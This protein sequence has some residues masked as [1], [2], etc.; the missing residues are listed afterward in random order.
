MSSIFEQPPHVLALAFVTLVSAAL[1]LHK[2]FT[3]WWTERT[4]ENETQEKEREALA[5]RLQKA[6]ELELLQKIR[7]LEEE[8]ESMGD[9]I[10]RLNR[11]LI[12]TTNELRSDGNALTQL[13][14]P[15]SRS[16]R[17]TP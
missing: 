16:G 8:K 5:I 17:W 2:F 3:D 15:A 6:T 9:E 10:R 7:D 11:R 1:L 14:P 12:F 13:L 4:T